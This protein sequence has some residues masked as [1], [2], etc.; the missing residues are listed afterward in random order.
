MPKANH[1]KDYNYPDHTETQPGGL[2]IGDTK[3]PA[4]HWQFTADIH[5]VLF[6]STMNYEYYK[7]KDKKKYLLVLTDEEK[8]KEIRKILLKKLWI[9]FKTKTYH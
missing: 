8:E 3:T 2:D 4:G 1:Y 7:N 9:K 6:D 5:H